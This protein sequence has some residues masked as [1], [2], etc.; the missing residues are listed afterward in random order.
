MSELPTAPFERILRNVGAERVGEDA[1]DKLREVAEDYSIKIA[2]R[3][4]RL[5]K[6]ASRKTVRAEDIK[7]A[8]S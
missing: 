3:A 6:H 1:K 2:T 7:M 8:E 5:A 4:V